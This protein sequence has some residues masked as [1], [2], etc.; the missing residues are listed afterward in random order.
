MG[1]CKKIIEHLNSEDPQEIREACFRIGEEECRD[2]IP[3][4]V[5]LLKSNNVGIQ[6]AAELSLRKL[7]GEESVEA[8]ISLL[9]EE[10]V[11]V[12]NVA[13]DILGVTLYFLI[14]G[15]FIVIT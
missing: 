12:R 10:D 1:N 7:G 6:E 14:A 9:W 8:L 13:I 2:G 3:Y 5:E 4:L 15:Y 11:A